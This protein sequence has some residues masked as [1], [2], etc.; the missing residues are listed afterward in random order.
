MLSSQLRHNTGVTGVLVLCAMHAELQDSE[1]LD[2]HPD[3]FARA[4]YMFCLN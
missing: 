2:F 1:E 4:I 3:R